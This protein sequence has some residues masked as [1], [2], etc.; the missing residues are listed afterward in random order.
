MKVLVTGGSGYIGSELVKV[1]RD[2]GQTPI[3]FDI[4]ADPRDDIRDET[5]IIEAIKS[6]DIVYHLASPCIVPE[7]IKDPWRYWDHIFRGTGNIAK[8][9]MN[10]NKRMI[11]TST[12]LAGDAFKCQCCGQLQ[13]PYAAAKR[14]A[15]K[16]LETMSNSITI[17]LP[18]IIDLEGRDPNDSRLFPRF[19]KMAREHGVVRIFPP[20]DTPVTLV[21]VHQCALNLLALIKEGTGIQTMKGEDLT[22]RQVAERVAALHGARVEVM[23]H[24]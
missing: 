4:I 14:E 5:R 15:E 17:R 12:Q 20:E 10:Y 6:V 13:S 19:N 8:A 11:F 18:N 24:K 2:A 7:S 23:Q 3:I 22:I 21:D 16:F 9:C 1:L